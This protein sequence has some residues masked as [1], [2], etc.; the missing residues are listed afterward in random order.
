MFALTIDKEDQ[1][2]FTSQNCVVW[3]FLDT[4]HIVWSVNQKWMFRR[5][6]TSQNCPEPSSQTYDGPIW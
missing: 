1:G 4:L 2:V 3:F 6:W 5:N